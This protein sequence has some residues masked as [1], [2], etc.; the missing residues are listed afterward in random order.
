MTN[1]S[2]T[3]KMSAN[4]TSERATSS[5]N[6]MPDVGGN[7]K[8]NDPTGFYADGKSKVSHCPTTD[9]HS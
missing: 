3:T 5:D 4:S 2:Q 7:E 8:L 1:T 9:A 6:E